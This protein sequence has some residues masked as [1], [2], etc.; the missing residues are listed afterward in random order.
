MIYFLQHVETKLIK[1]GTSN[2][3]AARLTNLTRMYGA[4]TVLCLI[5]GTQGEEALLHKQFRH[6]NVKGQLVGIEWFSPTPDLM[7]YIT[8]LGGQATT[9]AIVPKKASSDNLVVNNIANVLTRHKKMNGMNNTELAAML[10]VSESYVSRIL[11][12]KRGD[13]VNLE[14]LWRICAKLNLTPNDLLPN[15]DYKRP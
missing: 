15:H 5:E 14:V 3:F 9:G 4:F 10:E 7:D 12:D 11:N 13:K 8:K 2:F 1:I 6:A